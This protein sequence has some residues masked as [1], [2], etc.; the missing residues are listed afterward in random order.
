M[1]KKFMAKLGIGA[2]TVDL[3]LDREA[4]RLGEEMTGMIRIEGGTVEQRISQLNV[5]LIMKAYVKGQAVTRPVSSI[6]VLS[7]FVVQPKPHV[8]EVP[9]RYQLPQELAISTPSI[10]Y[11][12]Q[13]VLDVEMALDPTDM[14]RFTVLPP[15]HVEKVFRALERLD[16]R[17]KPDSGKLTRYG[18]EFSF[19]P[20]RP[21]NVPLREL[22]VIFFEG[23]EGLRLL[24]EMDVAQRGLFRHEK[25][26][27][28]EIIVPQELLKDGAEEQLT[29]FLDD[30]IEFY[31]NNPQAIPYFSL[32]GYGAHGYHGHHHGSH[33]MGGMIGGMAAGLLGGLL[34]GEMMEEMGELA[35]ADQLLGEG[36]FGSGDDG[37]SDGGDD[38]GG[39]GDFGDF[40]GFEE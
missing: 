31:L 10:E 24:V 1:F 11:Y 18:Q 16:F 15:A 29:R 17:Q 22:E 32:P 9:F 21:Y 38:G 30:K 23:P 4:F 2:A 8:Q 37:G 26:T 39:F 14:D 34:L 5:V 25:E 36:L 27:K 3:R 28:A 19:F 12:L 20:A 35:G 13:T 40:G 7:H 6:P 33:G